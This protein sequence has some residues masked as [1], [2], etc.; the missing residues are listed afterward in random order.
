MK[1]GMM[2][3]VTLAA[4]TFVYLVEGEPY[5]GSL[6]DYAKALEQC[7]YAGL[8]VGTDLY[9]WSEETWKRVTPRVRTSAYNEDDYAT[10]TIE[11]FGQSASVRIDGRA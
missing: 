9:W 5:V 2:P 10:M 1:F 3:G 7:H 4:T 6:A 8:D 11:A